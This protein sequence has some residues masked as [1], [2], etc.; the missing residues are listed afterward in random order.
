MSQKIRGISS[1]V[2]LL[3]FVSSPGVAGTGVQDVASAVGDLASQAQYMIFNPTAQQ[4]ALQDPMVQLQY[5]MKK[6]EMGAAE[7]LANGALRDLNVRGGVAN[8]VSN[9]FKTP[10][11][12]GVTALVGGKISDPANFDKSKFKLEHC[13]SVFPVP[14]AEPSSCTAYYGTG[15]DPIEKQKQD[16]NAKIEKELTIIAN[17]RAFLSW[18]ADNCAD[19]DQKALEAEIKVY[20]CKQAAM[21]NA[22]ALASNQLQTVL[23]ANQGEFKK[24]EQFVAEVGDQIRQVDELL[25]PEDEKL[26]GAEGDA[27]N[28]FKGLFGIQR[29]LNQQIKEM[30]TR[31]AEFKTKIDEIKTKTEA[32]DQTLES[33][34]MGEVSKCMQNGKGV[35]ISG[36]RA[37][38]CFVA[39]QDASGKKVYNKQAC[40]PMD[41]LKSQ[42]SQSA[43]ITSRGV[44]RDQRRTEESE[45]YGAEFESLQTAILRDLG[46]QDEKGEDGGKLVTRE[47]NWN[48]IARKHSAAMQEL[49]G[50]TGV[51]VSQQMNAI[52]GS[53]FTEADG[54]RKQQKRSLS[55]RY[56]KQKSEITKVK[57]EL[58]ANLRNDLSA[59]N[60]SY[61]DAM[62]VLSGQVANVNRYNCTADDPEKMQGCFVQMKQGVTDLLE[63]NGMSGTSKTIT[64]GTQAAPYALPPVTFACKGINGCITTLKGIR[65]GKKTQLATSQKVLVKFVNDS[66]ASVK[67]QLTQFGSALAALQRD[68]KSQFGKLNAS[69]AKMGATSVSE[70]ASIESE[71]LK[72]GD[73]KEGS[74][75]G[76]YENPTSM[77]KVLSGLMQPDG[78]MNFEENGLKE[79]REAAKEKADKKK[80]ELK[81]QLASFKDGSKEFKDLK[82]EC[83][84]SSETVNN[85][86]CSQTQKSYEDACR[87]QKIIGTGADA[88]SVMEDISGNSTSG[89]W[90]DRKCDDW[91]RAKALCANSSNKQARQEYEKLM[92]TIGEVG[93]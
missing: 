67:T 9:K 89:P 46:A 87:V 32:N 27:G 62:S 20:E 79:V 72:Q 11:E 60:K 34:R 73:A 23:Q 28:Q 37:L 70:P 33:E 38:T 49:S 41:W 65:T 10:G 4:L 86:D 35:S 47:T 85:I 54:W 64:G 80:E 88:I 71:A 48:D 52:A 56:N 74:I 83:L 36:G 43:F 92:N 63:G 19:R 39:K 93:K 22:V 31:E 6:C 12:A 59:V 26:A 25:G 90:K 24:G 18:K 53:C 8:L 57:D 2:V 77:S 7:R 68:L 40:G 66:N 84:G 45:N 58:S 55:S 81:E 17:Y 78:M 50:K 51:N 15:S 1:W 76:P 3:S 75:A 21:K 16:G 30:N 91:V 82:Q 5:E 13:D 44:M 29:A 42:V 69:L 14:S 61:G